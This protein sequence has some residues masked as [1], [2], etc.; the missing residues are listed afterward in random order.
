[1]WRSSFVLTTFCIL[2]A[3][4][5]GGDETTTGST[6]TTPTGTGGEGG[7][8]GSGGGGAGGGIPKVELAWEPC[9]LLSVGV[10]P[11]AECA[12]PEVPLSASDP[13]GKTLPFYVKRYS[14][15]GSSKATQL[16][17]L[18]GGPGVSGVIYEKLAQ[19]LVEDDDSL[20]IYIPDHRGTGD[21]SRLGCPAQEKDS[22]TWG[23]FIS[24]GEWPKC[25]ESVKE[26]WGDDLAA[27]N[28]TNAA[29]DVGVLIESTRREGARVFVYGASYGTFWGHR[30]LQLFPEQADGVIL[31]AILPP[32]ASIARQD[33]DADEAGNDLFQACA[34]DPACGPKLGGD[35]RAFGLA[36]YEK[37]DAGHCPAIQTNGPGRILLRRAFGQM[38]MSWHPRRLIPAAMARADRCNA[39]DED[40]IN[41]LFDV[42]HFAPDPLGE[43]VLRE[44]SFVLANHI[45]FSE[46]W[47]EPDITLDQMAAWRDGAV[48]SRDI[49]EQFAAPFAVMPRYA[50]DGHHQQFAASD[51]PLLMLQGTWDPATRPGPAKAMKEAHTGPKHYWVDI[52]FGAHGVMYSVP[53]SDGVLCGNQ[54]VKSFLQDP[55]SPPDTSCLEKVVQP[56]FDGDPPL[57]QALFGTAD[58]WGGL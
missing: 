41:A 36:L 48:V 44:N 2:W 13:A 35:P 7:S 8:G 40:A 1:M 24:P 12:R 15:A 5:C 22:S 6:T 20:E 58:A 53:T 46:L 39:E 18:T 51:R 57:N 26:Q 3:A 11:E 33:I 34:E 47:A 28:V 14:K 52:P 25:V 31:D 30:Y 4:G 19:L 45:A 56:S 38:M 17:M 29:H 32:V 50:P 49:T 23:F 37:L 16:W 10:G 54:I 43:I 21:S 42:Y 27:F 55:D 9:D